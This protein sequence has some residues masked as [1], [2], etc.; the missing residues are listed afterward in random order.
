M[1]LQL[2]LETPDGSPQETARAEQEPFDGPP[3]RR[4]LAWLQRIPLSFC[5]VWLALVVFAAISA[6]WLPWVQDPNKVKPV[7]RLQGP[8]IKHWFGTDQLGRDTFARA[9]RGSR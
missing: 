7:D 2:D 6:S 4:R 8:S 9:A 3:R 1:A 5:L